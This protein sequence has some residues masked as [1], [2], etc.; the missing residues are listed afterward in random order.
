MEEERK[1]N[2]NWLENDKFDCVILGTGLI[3]SLVAGALA[4]AGKSVLHFDKKVVYGGFESSFNLGQ[5]TTILQ[6]SNTNVLLDK[7]DLVPP[8]FE[9]V[10]INKAVQTASLKEEENQ[11]KQEETISTTTENKEE[12]K[13]E[14]VETTT[15]TA[16]TTM[17][18]ENI[19][20]NDENVN[21]NNNNNE[22]EVLQVI[23]V[24]LAKEKTLE[25]L[26]RLFSIDIS[27]TLLYGRGALVKLL[28]SSSASRYLEF[29]SLDQNYLFANGKVH[30]IPSTKGSIFK[31]STFSL[32]EK[33][34][35]MKFMESIRDLKKEG[36]DLDDSKKEEHFK[37][38]IAE[39]GK[40]YKNF[41][42]YIKSYKFTELVESFILY[43]LSLIHEDLDSIPLET[44]I[45][46]VSLY[47]SSLLVYG[48]SPFLVP[49]YGVGD[50]PQAFCRLCAVFGGS[51][52]LGRSVDS[53]QF[54]QETGK[55][56]SIICS[57]GQTIKTNH[58]IT[59][60]KYLNT[61]SSQNNLIQPQKTIRKTY[62]RFIGI[63]DSKII[64]TQNESFI[65]IP[66]KSI[67][68]KNKNVI[69]ILQL[70]SI[71]VPYNKNKVLVH[72]T[73]LAESTAENDLKEC[74]EQILKGKKDSEKD[75]ASPSL[76]WSTYFNYS[77]DFV[78]TINQEKDNN[79]VVCSD[80]PNG[81]TVDFEYHISQAKKIFET[82]C[83][84]Q[85]F[86]EKV[87]DA[88]D[89]IHF[90]EPETTETTTDNKETETEQKVETEQEQKIE[91]EEENEK[92]QKIETE[93]KE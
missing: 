61:I 68:G 67:N 91:T 83:P 64:G 69:N 74:V 85:I 56:E 29:K 58:F 62:S 9:N 55:V 50:I 44:G 86:L 30:E 52:V 35:I 81:Q 70:S 25:E 11:I 57:E 59:S 6:E 33:R 45:E 24:P 26:G 76:L 5:L 49:Y 84:G 10:V 90:E 17:T 73:T 27:P 12:D 75:S 77:V 13:K 18:T 78:E 4:R 43:G 80:S 63:I 92:E 40:Q 54:N 89:I 82:I 93:K 19:N 66:P 3:E 31:D 8:Y 34:L 46:S 36:S 2:S 65:T 37:Q 60:P 47:T 71:C 72:F 14:K 53:I 32:K 42:D 88:D 22:P 51:Y 21:D 48:V 20:N 28:I 7:K 1:N 15:T 23:D 38:S 16:A 41:I 39:L 79:I 87:P